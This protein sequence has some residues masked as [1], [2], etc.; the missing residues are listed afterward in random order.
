MRSAAC[1]AS[2]L[3]PLAPLVRSLGLT[4][5]FPFRFAFALAFTFTFDRRTTAVLSAMPISSA[6]PA[7][8]VAFAFTFLELT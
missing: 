4:F 1:E 5:A 6:F 8:A 7:S 3:G 2:S